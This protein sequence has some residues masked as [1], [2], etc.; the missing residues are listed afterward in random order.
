MHAQKRTPRAMT[1]KEQRAILRATADHKGGLR[2]HVLYS[3]AL[4]TGLRQHELVALNCGDVFNSDGRVRG[5]VQLHTFKRCTDSPRGQEVILPE[6]LRRKLAKLRKALA[7][8]AAGAPLF[9]SRHGSRLSAQRARSAFKRW[10]QR[11][12]LEREFTFHELRHTA[13]TNIY[14][15]TTDLRLAQRFGRHASPVTTAIYAHVS[16]EALAAAVEDLIC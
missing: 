8:T 1:E 15:A 6:A 12:G 7:S 11:A 9:V 10:Q 5:R 3:V 16:D 13:I 4:A 14:R 2:D